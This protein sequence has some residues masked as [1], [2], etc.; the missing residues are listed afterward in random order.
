MP[1]IL[2]SHASDDFLPCLGIISRT[3]TLGLVFLSLILWFGHGCTSL[4]ENWFCLRIYIFVCHLNA[5]PSY[6]RNSQARYNFDCKTRW[7][8]KSKVARKNCFDITK[9]HHSHNHNHPWLHSISDTKRCQWPI[10]GEVKYV[11]ASFYR[12]LV[13]HLWEWELVAGALSS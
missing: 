2:V 6:I 11:L 8:G 10:W 4:F 9:F 1:P 5:K 7:N 3:R 12:L 13:E